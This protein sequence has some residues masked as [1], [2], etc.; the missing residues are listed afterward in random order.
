[1]ES[2]GPPGLSSSCQ[3]AIYA[4]SDPNFLFSPW[5]VG[6]WL[7]KGTISPMAAKIKPNQHTAVKGWQT[8]KR[9][10]QA[11]AACSS[12]QSR[13]PRL[14]SQ[15]EAEMGTQRLTETQG[16]GRGG[17][18]HPSAQASPA[19]HSLCPADPG[20]ASHRPPTPAQRPPETP[21]PGGSHCGSPAPSCESYPR[22][23]EEP[24]ASAAASLKSLRAHLR[25]CRAASISSGGFLFRGSLS[26]HQGTPRT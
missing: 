8:V 7:S 12:Q 23:A 21:P 1:M 19:T 15:R 11:S 10:S 18:P 2:V 22:V 17:P 20:P 26:V 3:R 5:R 14:C 4:T 25:G 6:R 9:C 13:I 24:E 16:R